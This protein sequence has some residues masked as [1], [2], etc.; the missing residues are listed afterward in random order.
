MHV[1]NG[2][3]A[4]QLNHEFWNMVWWFLEGALGRDW[5]AGRPQSTCI[6]EPGSPPPGQ[7]HATNVWLVVCIGTYRFLE[8]GVW[9]PSF[10]LFCV[11]ITFQPEHVSTPLH[12]PGL[13]R[14]IRSISTFLASLAR[15][16]RLH[17]RNLTQTLDQGTKQLKTA[18]AEPGQR[19]FR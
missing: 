9:L 18:S 16:V 19:R 11:H 2:W 4:F 15:V 8:A 5:M 17:D 7:L 14:Q 10:A 3:H 6:Y 1:M 13:A 12:R